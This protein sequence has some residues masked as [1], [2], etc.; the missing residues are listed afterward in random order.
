[1][2]ILMKGKHRL[3]VVVSSEGVVCYCAGVERHGTTC[4]NSDDFPVAADPMQQAGGHA[5]EVHAS[6][7][8]LHQ[9]QRDQE[10]S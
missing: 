2:L 7:H 10:G 1:M 5:D 3:Q 9:A 8:P 4:L 6:L